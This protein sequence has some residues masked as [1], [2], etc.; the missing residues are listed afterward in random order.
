MLISLL[1]LICAFTLSLLAAWRD[2]R[3]MTIPD[4]FTGAIAV[5]FAPAFAADIPGATGLFNTIGPQLA[6]AA[7][8][9]ALTFILF[10]VRGLGGGDSK[11]ATV[12][13]LWVGMG[14]LMIFLTATV[15]AGGVIALI[16][17][18]AHG[19]HSSMS[20]ARKRAVAYAPALVFGFMAAMLVRIVPS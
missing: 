14:G 18:I 8:V 20:I 1:C 3:T 16:L 17:L 15:L 5:L 12:L 19:H 13:A 7:L 11:L 10:L 4:R 2:M 9:F 6:A